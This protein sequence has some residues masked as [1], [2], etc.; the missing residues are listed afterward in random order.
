[1]NG[2]RIYTKLGDDGSTG[3]LYGGRTSKADPLMEAVGSIDE[4][5]STLGLARASGSDAELNAAILSVQRDLFVAAADLV[6]NPHARERLVPGISLLTPEMVVQLERLIDARMAAKPLRP[7]FVV[8][9]ANL[10]SAALDMARTQVRRAERRLVAYARSAQPAVA[11]TLNPQVGIYLNRVSDL[12]Y[13]LA[14]QAAGD[15]EEPA[16]HDGVPK[17]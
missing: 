10:A 9:G 6:T 15:A 8:P 16:S 12:L 14:R 11:D 4:T 2:S 17:G 3:L 13:V 5:V 7:V 1:M